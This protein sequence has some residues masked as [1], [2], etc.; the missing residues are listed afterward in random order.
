MLPSA[1]GVSGYNS[2]TAGLMVASTRNSMPHAVQQSKQRSR[3][4][5]HDSLPHVGSLGVASMGALH[6]GDPKHFKSAQ[7]AYQSQQSLSTAVNLKPSTNGNAR[8]VG[9]KAGGLQPKKAVLPTH[10]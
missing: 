5:V 7:A 2:V 8:Y 10:C 6:H 9:G 3:N 4:G 1:S